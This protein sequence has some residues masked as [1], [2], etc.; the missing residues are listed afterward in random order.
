MLYHGVLAPNAAGRA[1]VVAFGAPIEAP[2]GVGASANG[3]GDSAAAPTSRHW[4]WPD[5]MR[6]A[7]EVDALACPRCRGRL[8]LV[9]TVEDPDAIRTILATVAVSR[10]LAARAPPFPPS[11]ANAGPIRA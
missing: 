6:R 1:R 2:V 11:L 8:R 7:F 9:A 4:A 10:E 3:T 5:L